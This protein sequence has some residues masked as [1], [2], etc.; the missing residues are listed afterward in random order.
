MLCSSH[1]DARPAA[2]PLRMATC[3][4]P[5]GSDPRG[6]RAPTAHGDTGASIQAIADRADVGFGS[7]QN[8]R[9]TTT[10]LFDAAVADALDEFSRAIDERPRGFVDDPAELVAAGFRL[11]ARMA[12]SHPKPVQILRHRGLHA[13]GARRRSCALCDPRYVVSPTRDRDVQNLRAPSG[14]FSAPGRDFRGVR[15]GLAESR[16]LWYRGTT[17]TPKIPPW[18]HGPALPRSYLRMQTPR[19]IRGRFHGRKGPP[20]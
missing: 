13:P 14:N 10:E 17:G 19:R 11:M 3:R 7:F 1:T 6:P 9:R 8:H 4:D 2:Q 5:Q 15:G 12:D 16:S 20:P 18:A